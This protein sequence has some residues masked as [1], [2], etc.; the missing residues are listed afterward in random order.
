MGI[1]LH[2]LAMEVDDLAFDLLLGAEDMPVIL[3]KATHTHE[4]VQGAGRLIARAR[5][6]FAI[7][8]R[9]FA[10]AVQ[11]VVVDQ[12]MARAIHR[13]QRVVAAFR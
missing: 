4:A 9:Q 6:E 8:D 2:R 7:A 12:H 1:D 5:T 10:V 13:L 3:D 11:P